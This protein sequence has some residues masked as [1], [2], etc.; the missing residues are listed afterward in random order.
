M[1]DVT[2]IRADGTEATR[3]VPEGSRVSDVLDTQGQSILLNDSE[4]RGR[5]PE[6]RD[7]DTVEVVRSKQKGGHV[8]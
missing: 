6:L 5:D 1:M 3:E 4:V 8:V 7:G 2:I